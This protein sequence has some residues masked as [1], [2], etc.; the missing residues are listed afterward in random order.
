MI[1]MSQGNFRW[2]ITGLVHTIEAFTVRPNNIFLR[3]YSSYF[4]SVSQLEHVTSNHNSTGTF[5]WG[6][7]LKRYICTWQAMPA[8]FRNILSFFLNVKRSPQNPTVAKP[9]LCEC[10]SDAC[11]IHTLCVLF[12]HVK[13]CQVHLK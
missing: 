12:M 1:K 10:H 13:F 8:P 6:Q 3:W 2:F 9:R 11:Y 4:S 5:T 7:F